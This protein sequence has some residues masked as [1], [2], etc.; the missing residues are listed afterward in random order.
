MSM[1][2]KEAGISFESIYDPGFFPDEDVLE[3][4]RMVVY[5]IHCTLSQDRVLYITSVDEPNVIEMPWTN[6]FIKKGFVYHEK[7]ETVSPTCSCV[8]STP[9]VMFCHADTEFVSR[10]WIKMHV[11]ITVSSMVMHSNMDWEGGEGGE[12]EG[13]G[14]NGQWIPLTA[15]SLPR[16]MFLPVT[17]NFNVIRALTTRET[18]IQSQL[19]QIGVLKYPIFL[20]TGQIVYLVC[21]PDPDGILQIKSVCLSDTSLIKTVNVYC[22]RKVCL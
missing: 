4:S 21:A 8:I 11:F 15:F 7:V 22:I 2:C 12:G 5:K 14:S 9:M 13:K 1:I 19:F 20:Q 10:P 17:I 18:E 16:V 3:D 6:L